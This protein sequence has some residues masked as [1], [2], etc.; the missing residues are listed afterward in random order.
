[1]EKIYREKSAPSTNNVIKEFESLFVE[2]KKLSKPSEE[3]YYNILV[4]LTEAINNAAD[5]GNGL[6]ED[7]E[8]IVKLSY[9][10]NELLCEVFDKGEGFDVE[11][12]EDPREPHNLLKDSG[13]GIFIMKELASNFHTGYQGNYHF[14]KMTFKLK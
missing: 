9:D 13:R 4:A 14:V 2:F 3:T 10:E 8:V 12:V 1:M 7:Q 6:D 11:S 5:H